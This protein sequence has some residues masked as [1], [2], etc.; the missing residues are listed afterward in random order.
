MCIGSIWSVWLHVEVL[1]TVLFVLAISTPQNWTS[2]VSFSLLTQCYVTDLQ[3]KVFH[4]YFNTG[5]SRNIGWLDFPPRPYQWYMHFFTFRSRIRRNLQY[6]AQH[7]WIHPNRLDNLEYT[8]IIDICS[9][10]YWEMNAEV[11]LGCIS[12]HLN[13]AE[14]F[15][16]KFK[17]V[18]S[19]QIHFKDQN[20]SWFFFPK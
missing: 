3:A 7:K 12:I 14:D 11:T 1:L 9:Y 16:M 6:S 4:F 20:R 19:K 15:Q 17:E 18:N 8:F 5:V 13:T 2:R 10:F